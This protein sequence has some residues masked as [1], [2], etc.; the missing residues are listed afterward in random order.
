MGRWFV[1]LSLLLSG[2]GHVRDF[3]AEKLASRQ[4]LVTSDHTLVSDIIE[5]NPELLPAEAFLFAKLMLDRRDEK[6]IRMSVL[7]LDG[8]HDKDFPLGH[9]TTTYF[10]TTGKRSRTIISPRGNFIGVEPGEV[11]ALC[12]YH[13]Y[14]AGEGDLSE[15]VSMFGA[16]IGNLMAL[17][18]ESSSFIFAKPLMVEQTASP[19]DYLNQCDHK[20]VQHFNV[21]GRQRL[22]EIAANL[23][24][25]LPLQTCLLS[26]KADLSDDTEGDPGCGDWYQGLPASLQTN[27]V[28]R[29][30]ART[31]LDNP[32]GQCEL[33]ANS[34][35]PVPLFR[36]RYDIVSPDPSFRRGRLVT[37]PS[38]PQFLCDR[39][40]GRRMNVSTRG[41]WLNPYKATCD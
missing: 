9:R 1:L 21:E 41:S 17:R 24:L 33:R 34:D 35:A 28:P 5:E 31:V 30:I 39:E 7:A 40:A 16:P 13:P 12:V 10:L 18:S 4:P 20:Y 2:C 27:T 19:I 22:N 32:R 29:C 23:F 15:R 36:D 11:L 6:P 14:L 26:D 38:T 8:F 3:S 25:N 37:E